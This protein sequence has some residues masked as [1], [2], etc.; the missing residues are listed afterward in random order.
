MAHLADL[1]RHHHFTRLL[2]RCDIAIGQ[3]DHVDDVGLLG[4]I[5]HFSGFFIAFCKW[6]LAED[7]LARADQRKSGRMMNGIRRDIGNRIKAAPFQ[8]ILKPREA[9]VDVVIF[10]E[11]IDT[12]RRNV[13]CSNHLDALDGLEGFGM[14]LPCRL[15][16]E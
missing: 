9:V 16:P 10:G 6:F 2:Q 14:V 8:R 13:T 11:G 5:R 7:M 3:V 12:L 15:F 4:R 1:S